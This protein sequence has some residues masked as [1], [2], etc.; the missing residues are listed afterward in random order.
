ME[1]HVLLTVHQP[2][3]GIHE[4]LGRR[5]HDVG[6]GRVP[7]IEHPLVPQADRHLSHG[8]DALSDALDGELHQLIGHPRQVVERLTDRIHGPG[9]DRGLGELGAIGGDQS[10]GGGGLQVGA[11]AHLHQLEGESRLGL[12]DV[13][14]DDRFEVPVGD[15]TLAVGQLLEAGE[16]VIEVAALQ[17]VAEFLEPRPEGAAAA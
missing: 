6:I 9:A 2:V 16:G 12:L 5:H 3:E 11:R 1:R 13:L 7:G 8:V 14:A 17:V 15:L 4:G 10:D